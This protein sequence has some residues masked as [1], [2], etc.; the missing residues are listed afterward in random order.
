MLK[1]PIYTFC[2]GISERGEKA[3]TNDILNA[4]KVAEHIGSIHTEVTFTRE[5]A[6]NVIP[7]VIRNI[8]TWC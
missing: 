2:C 7:E 1:T 6:L 8:G 3:N 5:E 4:R